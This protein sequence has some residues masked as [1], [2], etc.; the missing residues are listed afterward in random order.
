MVLKGS[1]LAEQSQHPGIAIQMIV[2]D[3]AMT[4]EAHER[5]VT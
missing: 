4:E 2:E 3:F 5:D 1:R